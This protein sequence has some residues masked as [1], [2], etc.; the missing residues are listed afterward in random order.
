MKTPM[1]HTTYIG[2]DKE[3][4]KVDETQYWAMIG[5]L[6]YFTVSRPDIMFS[7]CLCARFQQ[8]P[9]ELQLTAIKHIFRYLIETCNLVILL[10]RRKKN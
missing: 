3:S 2:P 9:R 8:E 5:S 6:L 4:T 10:K 7:V 1:H